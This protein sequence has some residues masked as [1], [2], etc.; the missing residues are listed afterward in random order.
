MNFIAAAAG[1]LILFLPAPHGLYVAADSRHDG[2]DPEQADEAR[3]IFLCGPRGVCAISGA[4][5]LTVT[6][7]DGSSGE[8]DVA[9]E[10]ARTAR[11]APEDGLAAFVARRMDAA[12]RRFWEENMNEPVSTRLTAR[13]QAPSVCT[14]LVVS[15]QHGLETARMDQIQFPFEER[16]AA[17]GAF[18]HEL[19]EPVIRPADPKRP[20]AQGKTECMMITADT[21]PAVETREETLATIRA[22]YARTQLDPSCRS[23]IGGPVDIAV[24]LPDGAHW[25]RRKGQRIASSPGWSATLND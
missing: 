3:K 9:G 8:L 15:A 2:G 17:D 5:R 24:I 11:D 22:L 7:E 13:L 14:I 12:I 21:P 4:L 1:T 25:L 16:P 20:L 6:K 23:I 10:L 18:L 19:K